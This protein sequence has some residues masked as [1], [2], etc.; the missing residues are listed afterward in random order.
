MIR[1][2]ILFTR[3]VLLERDTS[4]CTRPHSLL[5]VLECDPEVGLEG[6]PLNTL[7]SCDIRTEVAKATYLRFCDPG[8]IFVE[9]FRVEV[10]EKLCNIFMDFDQRKVAADAA[11]ATHSEL[12][13]S[14]HTSHE[15]T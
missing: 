1:K 2:S 7:I 9:N 13:F 6:E 11:S 8:V 5:P 12:V 3:S 4:G 14:K 10:P 15:L